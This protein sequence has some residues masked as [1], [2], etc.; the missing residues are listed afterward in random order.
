MKIIG[1]LV[2]GALLGTFYLILFTGLAIKWLIQKAGSYITTWYAPAYAP[3]FSR[4]N[5]LS[6]TR[7]L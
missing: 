2:M 1:I 7:K 6:D 3:K 5:Q 4:K